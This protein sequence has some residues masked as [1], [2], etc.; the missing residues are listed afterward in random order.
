MS[1]TGKITAHHLD[2]RAVVYVRQSTAAQVH[3]HRESTD[4]QYQLTSRASELGWP[5]AQIE[6]IDQDL[7][8]SGGATTRREGFDQLTS[9][10]ALGGV[11]IVFFLD[12][13]GPPI[14]F[15]NWGNMLFRLFAGGTATA[16]GIG[17][18]A[19]R[20]NLERNRLVVVY[21]TGIKYWAFLIS[22]YAY[23][24][25]NL[26]LWVVVL[27]GVPNLLLAILLTYY[28]RREA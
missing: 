8:V 27:F 7:G 25:H 12:Y 18:Y 10:V 5:H 2:R 11:G 17:H 14:G 19:A 6:V 26:S 4:R 15:T 1:N 21:G 22:L 28:L 13:L 23:L 24:F 9:M 3:E 20:R 16:F